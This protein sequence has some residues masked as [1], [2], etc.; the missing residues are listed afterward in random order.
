[1]KELKNKPEFLKK[2]ALTGKN[3]VDVTAITSA[4]GAEWKKLSSEEK[5]PYEMMGAEAKHQYEKDMDKWLKS[6]TPEDIRRQNLYF[7]HQRKRGIKTPSNIKAPGAPK[8][9]P[10]AFLLFVTH[11]RESG[12]A[13]GERVVDIS[14]AAG[15]KWKELSAAEKEPFEKDAHARLHEWQ[16]LN[17][18]YKAKAK[19]A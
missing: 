9:P 13:A 1:M 11:L 15:S 18:A 3:V 8:K 10:G 6:L 19:S 16:K 5:H 4:A 2:S 14:K 17:D 7:A 12:N